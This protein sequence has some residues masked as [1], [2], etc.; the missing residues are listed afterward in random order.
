MECEGGHLFVEG[1][2]ED[3]VFDGGWVLAGWKER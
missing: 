1:V 2:N 3:G